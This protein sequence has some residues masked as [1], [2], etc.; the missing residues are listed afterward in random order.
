MS[1][2][3]LTQPVSIDGLNLPLIEHYFQRMNAQD[4]QG[5]AELFVSNGELH[6]PFEE[7]VIG[8]RAIAHYLENEAMGMK[9]FP[10][11]G[12]EKLLEDG[13]TEVY[14]KGYVKTSLFKVNVAWQF[15][16]DGEQDKILAVAVKL[17]ASWEELAQIQR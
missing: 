1:T 17:L 12:N 3:S 7:P 4:F 14:V 2:A 6:P 16:I 11:R 15:L 8:D 13:K 5:V 9:L 10:N